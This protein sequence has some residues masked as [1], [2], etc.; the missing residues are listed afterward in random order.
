VSDPT[1]RLTGKLLL[2]VGIGGLVVGIAGYNLTSPSTEARYGVEDVIAIGTFLLL[3]GAIAWALGRIRSTVAQDQV[4][5]GLRRT[6]FLLLVGGVLAAIV[7]IIGGG[8]TQ[9]GISPRIG[10]GTIVTAGFYVVIIGAVIV[11]LSHRKWT[12]RA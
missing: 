10:I 6:G 12:S 9:L 7:G 5:A 4:N 11:A 8:L 1:L 3:V 2:T